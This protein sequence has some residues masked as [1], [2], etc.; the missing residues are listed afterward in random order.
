MG[1]DWLLMGMGFLFGVMKIS[2]S[3]MS[4]GTSTTLYI[5]KSQTIP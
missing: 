3:K 2:N 4:G 1:S 5:L